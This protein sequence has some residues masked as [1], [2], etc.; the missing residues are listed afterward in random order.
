VTKE[1]NGWMNYETW[2]VA[3]WFSNDYELYVFAQGFSRWPEPFIAFREALRDEGK[4]ETA[5]G[6]S[7]WDS[8]LDIESLNEAIVEFRGD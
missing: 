6:V 2:N 8:K 1:Y 7:F 4:T 3:L 5:D